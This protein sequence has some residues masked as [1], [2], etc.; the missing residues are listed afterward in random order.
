[1][2]SFAANLL[3]RRVPQ[4]VGLYIAAMWMAV[5]IGDWVTERFGLTTSLTS[6]LFLAMAILL[7]SV[8][9]L[10]YGHG[11]PGQ[12]QWSRTEKVLVPANLIAA[13]IA[14]FIF[15]P[16][17]EAVA[18][19]ETKTMMNE[20]EVEQT[21]TVAAAGQ[22]KRIYIAFLDNATGDADLDWL[23]A[24]IPWLIDADL[25]QNI[26]V[27]VATPFSSGAHARLKHEG[28]AGG[29][30]V[31]LSLTL[32][33]ARERN[34]RFAAE[35]HYDRRGEEYAVTLQL[36]DAESGS[37]SRELSARGESVQR[38]VDE[39][40]D[41]LG[42]ALEVPDTPRR[43]RADLPVSELV[44]ESLPAIRSAIRG[45]LASRFDN[46][47]PSAISHQERA[48]ELDS[49]FVHAI[50]S[51]GMSHYFM[52]QS[53]RASELLSDA[54]N[55]DY[56]LSEDMRFL[57]KALRYELQG[58]IAKMDK[59]VRLWTEVSPDNARAWGM[60]GQM[61]QYRGNAYP[62][63]LQALQRQYEL[64]PTNELLK[65]IARVEIVLGDHEDARNR[66]QRYLE[67]EPADTEALIQLAQLSAL[68]GDFEDARSALERGALIGSSAAE[69]ELGLL[70][71][72]IRTGDL[73][74][75]KSRIRA[76][77]EEALGA[78]ESLILLNRRTHLAALEGRIE[79]A[80]ALLNDGEEELRSKLPP[81]QVVL[82][83]GFTRTQLLSLLGRTE[84]ALA[85]TEEMRSQLEGPIKQVA[86]LGNLIVY[87]LLRSEPELEAAIEEASQ[88]VQAFQLQP[89]LEAMVDGSRG[90]LAEIRGDHEASV[91]W[92]RE[93]VSKFRQFAI[94]AGEASSLAQIETDLAHSLVE[95]GENDEARAVLDKV[96]VY[97]PSFS[98]AHLELA[99]H[100]RNVG[101][102]AGAQETLS[103][104]MHQ[105]RDADPEYIF[106]RRAVDLAAELG[107]ELALSP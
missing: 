45:E 2:S 11:A 81:I 83:L 5:E 36:Y 56:K 24:G 103:A 80:L 38:V 85:A 53:E 100:Q 104:L 18:A 50:F 12:D 37:L 88:I 51:L 76:L 25:D 73:E 19:V 22:V 52:G 3:H 94:L 106:Y 9:L 47:F 99:S 21:F 16:G 65:D 40:S 87:A 63:A 74:S 7:P 43:L 8:A 93:A 72:D 26:F 98:P 66:L 15:Q 35:G 71:M 20:E 33:L 1:M 92:N 102:L 61:L 75:A 28:F 23:G 77:E 68:E 84:E 41:G 91:S 30:D 48:V 17:R 27:S 70:E 62:E 13:A 82:T 32:E 95:A 86:G 101:D 57:I 64:D 44:S 107:M 96:F 69:S 78:K 89:T 6:Y 90:V 10:A 59:V 60:L 55:L 46:D 67:N 34:A 29:A 39:L 4:I 42:E 14:L 49:K 54:L 97:Y 31:P 105:W 79:H 58:D